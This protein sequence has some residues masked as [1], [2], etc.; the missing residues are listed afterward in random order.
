M[1]REVEVKLLADAA[2]PTEIKLLRPSRV[3]ESNRKLPSCVLLSSAE[4]FGV[5][6]TGTVSAGNCILDFRKGYQ[7]A[8]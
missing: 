8:E 6:A 4:E 5:G 1:W 7:C 3:L 2:Y